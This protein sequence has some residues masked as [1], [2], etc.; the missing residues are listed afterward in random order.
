MVFRSVLAV[1]GGSQKRLWLGPARLV[2]ERSASAPDIH[3]CEAGPE[4]GGVIWRK[5]A[6]AAGIFAVEFACLQWKVALRCFRLLTEG[7]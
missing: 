7:L 6:G 3:T 5:R 2:T 4:A 1:M